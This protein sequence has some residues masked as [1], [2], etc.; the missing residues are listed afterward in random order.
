MTP[1]KNFPL[2][3]A[4]RGSSYAAPENTIAAF[5][6]AIEEGADGIEMDV[7][8]TADG[9]PV[10]FHDATLK[11]MTGRD[12]WVSE[13]DHSDLSRVRPGDWFNSRYQKRARP[14]YGSLWVPTLDETLRRLE[15]FKGPVFVELKCRAH[16]A[17]RVVDAVGRVIEESRRPQDVVIKSFIPDAVPLVI[18]RCGDVRTAALFAP[19]VMSVIRKKK[20]LINI[21]SDLR[22]DILSLHF[23]L[24]TRKLM[25]RARKA[26]LEVAVWTVN[27]PRWMRRAVEL[28]IDSV[29]TNKPSK[30][31]LRRRQ[32]LHRN[33]ITA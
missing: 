4:H 11:R 5:E 8:V 19:K 22:A 31:L 10:V 1:G 15:E 14:E 29:I 12:I 9:I 33:S 2:I 6:L 28:G 21:A 18:E 13:V 7:R 30:M 23:S 3:I 26:G 24:A 32:L 27:N 25:K 16:E 20:R 17:G